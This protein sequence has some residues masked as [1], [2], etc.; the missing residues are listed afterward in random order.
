METTIKIKKRCSFCKKTKPLSEFSKDRNRID[1]HRGCCKSCIKADHQSERGRAVNRKALA[2]YNKT[3]KGKQANWR[4]YL[5]SNYGVSVEEYNRMFTIQAGCCGIC[6][7]HQSVN[8]NGNALSVDH[9]H[10]TKQVRGLLC[11]T[12]NRAIGQLKIDESGVALFLKAIDYINRAKEV[13]D[14]QA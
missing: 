12:C 9:N 2:K 7:K 8:Q 11:G 4:L 10:I 3:P 14:G 5:R 6:G 13:T 1:G